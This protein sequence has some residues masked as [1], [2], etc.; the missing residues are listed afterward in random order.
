MCQCMQEASIASITCSLII[1]RSEKAAD[2]SETLPT[3]LYDN[4][5]VVQVGPL[6]SGEITKGPSER[7]QSLQALES[8]TRI[9]SGESS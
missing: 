9:S 7:A 2:H 6:A 8:S 3:Y 1:V 4:S 5:A